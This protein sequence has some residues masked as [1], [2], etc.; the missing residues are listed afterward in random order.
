MSRSKWKGLFLQNILVKKKLIFSGK[1]RNSTITAR[2]LDKL[3]FIST[4][5]EFKKVYISKEKIGLKFGN[6]AYTRKLKLKF[7]LKIRS[8]KK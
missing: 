5:K 8:K 4:G 7:K 3:V 6:F 1:P 2:Y